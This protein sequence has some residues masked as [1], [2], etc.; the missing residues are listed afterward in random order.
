MEL[1]YINKQDECSLDTRLSG[2]TDAC[3]AKIP[4]TGNSGDIIT[5]K[6]SSFYPLNRSILSPPISQ[7]KNLSVKFRQHDGSLID[8]N[9]IDHSFTLELELMDNNFDEF[10][11]ME[12]TPL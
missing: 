6:E 11:S 9:N 2:R 12:F 5:F 1:D 3:F 4:I 7:L 8:F 10:S